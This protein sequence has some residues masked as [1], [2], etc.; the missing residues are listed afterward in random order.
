LENQVPDIDPKENQDNSIEPSTQKPKKRR[1]RRWIYW[2]SAFFL[3]FFVIIPLL[4]NFYADRIFGET[5]REIIRLETDGKYTFEYDEIGFNLF[6]RDLSITNLQLRPDTTIVDTIT[7]KIDLPEKY[8][9]LRFD[10]LHIRLEGLFSAILDRELTVTTIYLGK[11]KIK[12]VSTVVTS[13][14]LS[15]GGHFHHRY[16]HSYIK[17]Y[18]SLLKIEQL[19]VDSCLFVLQSLTEGGDKVIRLDHVSIDVSNF[20]LDSLA[21]QENDRLF[22]SDS[23]GISIEGGHFDLKDRNHEVAFGSINMSSTERSIELLDVMIRKDSSDVDE[24]LYNIAVPRLA[25]DGLDFVGL[26]DGEFLGGKLLIQKPVINLTMPMKQQK[27]KMSENLE[28]RIFDE[29]ASVFYPVNIEQISIEHADLAIG[30][31][32][33]QAIDGFHIPNLSLDLY[34]IQIDSTKLLSPDPFYFISDINLK[35]LNQEFVLLKPGQEV[36]FDVLNFDTRN[37]TFSIQQL[38][39]ASLD[40]VQ[41]RLEATVTLPQLKVVGKDFKRD[42]IDRQLNLELVELKL[43]DINL[44]INPLVEKRE[45][46]VPF[47]NIKK[48]S[49]GLLNALTVD[50]FNIVDADLVIG[51]GKGIFDEQFTVDRV[52]VELNGFSLP[53]D[54]IQSADNIFYSSRIGMDLKSFKFMLPDSVHQLSLKELEIDTEKGSFNV[55][56]LYIDTLKTIVGSAFSYGDR[57]KVDVDNINASAID[58]AGI[59]KQKYLDL[60]DISILN[61]QIILSNAKAADNISK[62]EIPGFLKNYSIGSFMVK[63][64]NLIIEESIQSRNLIKCTLGDIFATDLKPFSPENYEEII[65]D[66]LEASFD[67]IFFQPRYGAQVI[68]TDEFYISQKDSLLRIMNFELYPGDFSV[69]NFDKGYALLI[70]EVEVSGFAVHRAI[71]QRELIV[72]DAI[73]DHTLFRVVTGK[74]GAETSNNEIDVAVLKEELLKIFGLWKL[75]NIAFRNT[76]LEAYEGTTYNTEIIK[77][78]DFTVNFN[79]VHIEHSINM[80]HNNVLFTNDIQFQLNRPITYKG[81]EDHLV[82]LEDFSLSTKNGRIKAHRFTMTEGQSSINPDLIDESRAVFGFNE[83]DITG[84]DFY[85]LVEENKLGVENIILDEPIFLL[86][87]EY[88]SQEHKLETQSEIN[89]YQYF[90]D[91]YTEARIDAFEINNAT[92]K[93]IDTRHGNKSEFLVRRVDVGLRNVLIDSANS[94][95]GNNFLYSDN[96]DLT[97]ENYSYNTG[98]GLYSVGASNIIFSSED[99]LLT[100]DSGYVNPLLEPDAFAKK[101]GVQTDRFDFTFD[102]ARLENFRL[103]DLFFNNYFRADYFYLTGLEG[104]DYRDKSYERPKNHF[105]NLP[106]T[107]LK[108]LGIGVRLDSAT[109]TDSRFMYRE[110]LKPATQPGRIWFDDITVKARN[111]TNDEELISMNRRM[112]FTV[113]TKLMGEGLIDMTILFDLR[114]E[115]DFRVDAVLNQMDLTKMNPLLEHIAFVKVKKGENELLDFHFTADKDV[116]RGNMD[117][118]YN[119]LAIRLID[120]KT[121]RDKGFGESMA[122]FV[123]NTFVVRSRNP[124]WGIFPRNGTIYF[125][126]DKTKSFFNYLAKS[127]LSGVSSTIRGGNEERKE[128]RLKRRAEKKQAKEVNQ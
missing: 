78:P 126:R 106:V 89:L 124:L 48:L 94:V 73:A 86:K 120:K 50:R 64:L 68:A 17:D 79:D 122:S 54:S 33:P 108:N 32:L 11:P 4:V 18:L 72:E 8:I 58:F 125:Q 66:S 47:D 116:A 121:L 56:G 28:T 26:L 97:I 27:G 101:V 127:A 9:D 19:S 112:G 123:A 25:F 40:N 115:D 49:G 42:F 84:I 105:P 70:P 98:N 24:S 76:A 5:A 119:N 61:P 74:S 109:I 93:I 88:S 31:L 36:N 90:S 96:L 13:D 92:L 111:I 110:F 63:G 91:R 20:H 114:S 41:Q 2:L 67:H 16:L 44:D 77:I 80:N 12:Y 59:Y 65:T 100:I 46:K 10:E 57:M 99:A 62:N 15:N 6:S 34:K 35:L 85:G 55:E 69:E 51:K 113:K 21:Y 7:G 29:L 60:G 81:K 107:G 95:F 30:N 14:T 38:N 1:V 87:R 45:I 75:G 37:S 118:R 3:I 83:V 71:Y 117:F 103:Y 53:F 39:I 23:I 128:K 102:H 52:N 43:P 82:A 104:E 22:F